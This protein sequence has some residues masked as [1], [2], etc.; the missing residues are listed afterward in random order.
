ME[1]KY[2][3]KC[4][5]EFMEYLMFINC[6]NTIKLILILGYNIYRET[7]SKVSIKIK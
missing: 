3:F 6:S 1:I 7:P 5:V 2:D 4:C